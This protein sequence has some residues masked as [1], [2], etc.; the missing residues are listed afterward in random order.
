MFALLGALP[1]I[2]NIVTGITTAFF[3]A[4]VSLV[5]ARIG[6]D[7][8]VA[9]KLVAAAAQQEHENTAKLGIFA[10]NKFLTAL[11]IA[12]AIPLVGFEWKI[13]IWDTML[14]WGSTPAVHG[15]V[16][17]WGN[18]V[19]YFLFGAPTVMGIGKMWFGRDKGGE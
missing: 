14:G 6:G 15:Q 3:N 4:K 11:L 7:R 12:F 19:I 2:G 17:D 18:T 13:Y 10:S 8:D 16:A 5:Q 1:A 9:V